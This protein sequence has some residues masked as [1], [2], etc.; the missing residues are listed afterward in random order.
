MARETSQPSAEETLNQ[1]L[2][3][4]KL[5]KVET[6]KQV[7]RKT[8]Q[9]IHATRELIGTPTDIELT[10]KLTT[11]AGIKEVYWVPCS[12]TDTIQNLM[13]KKDAKGEINYYQ[14]VNE[15]SLAGAAA[16][17]Y[18]ASSRRALIH[19]Q[20][21][22][23]PNAAD[24]I[25]SFANVYKIPIPSIVTD[26]GNSLKDDS[27]PHQEIGKMTNILTRTVFKGRTHGDRLGRGIL[28]AA[29]KMLEETKD[30]YPSVLRL[31]PEAFRKVHKLSL[32]EEEFDYEK[33][34]EN[35]K[36]FVKEHGQQT[37]PIDSGEP[38]AREE[39][40]NRIK[41]ETEIKYGKDVALVVSNGY[42]SRAAQASIDRLG[43][44]Y[45]VGYMGGTLA[46][47]WGMAK[48]NP[49][50]N[51]VVIDGDQNAMMGKMTEILDHD[52]P[53]NLQWVIVDNRH[54][55]SVGTARSPIIPSWYYDQAWIIN[56]IPEKPG[57]FKAPRV[58]KRGA[59]FEDDISYME[60]R[61]G[62]LEYHAERFKDW[63]IAVTAEMKRNAQFNANFK[64]Y[65]SLLL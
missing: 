30:G 51:V 52:Y 33:Y 35:K 41:K 17:N 32:S 62:P 56:T 24:G 9:V 31:A 39:A 19:M 36:M 16:G 58:G 53:N 45:H 26:R 44:F 46:I 23:L 1:H 37:N 42:N 18:L 65:S 50:L 4:T 34:E 10:E 64:N 2:G 49:D 63:A 27:E 14:M 6:A 12:I 20:N 57:E 55:T 7:Y 25:I 3:I 59:Y 54:G 8:R 43:N 61:L 47:G 11:E 28:K 15:H 13:V 21:S 5:G 29:D 60:S 22:G 48:A 40:L 38:L